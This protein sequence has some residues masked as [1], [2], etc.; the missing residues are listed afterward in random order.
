MT[1]VKISLYCIHKWIDIVTTKEDARQMNAEERLVLKRLRE[2][3][4]TKVHD[5]IP[6]F[7]NVDRKKT[8]R[9][10][11]LAVCV[12]TNVKTSSE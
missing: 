6:S 8:K 4:K 12:T 3:F 1:L 5:G 11:E 7:K 10:V 9:E 2:I